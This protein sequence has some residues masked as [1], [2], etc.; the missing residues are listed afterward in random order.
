MAI[1][2]TQKVDYLWKKLGYGVTKTDINSNKAATNESI[3]SPLLLRGD[4][5]WSDAGTVPAVIP[6]A[7]SSVV[8]IYDDSGN[9]TATVETTAD[10]TATAFRTWK[11]GATDWI[12]PEMGS[13]YQVKVYIDDASEAAPQSTGTQIKDAQSVFWGSIYMIKSNFI[14]VCI[15]NL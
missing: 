4:K 9:G 10:A 5:V 14:K 7:T 1:T 13:T 2:D 15:F 8:Q 11:T 3:A 6:A 12:P